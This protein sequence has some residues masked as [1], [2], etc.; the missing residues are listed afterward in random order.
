[1]IDKIITFDN[2]KSFKQKLDASVDGELAKKQDV[3]SDLE[4]IRTKAN[5]AASA[6]SL[7]AVATSGEYD[8]LVNKPEEASQSDIEDLFPTVVAALADIKNLNDDPNVD[9]VYVMLSGDIDSG[10]DDIVFRKDAEIDLNGHEL[11]FDDWGLEVRGGAS[12]TVENGEI[13]S[14]ESAFYVREQASLTINRGDYTSTNNF[15]IGTNGTAGK[16]DNTITING[17]TFNAEMSAAGKAEGYI[18]C[19]I[20]VANS[21]TL[22]VKSGTVLNVADGVGILCRSGHTVIEDGVIIN[23]TGTGTGYVGDSK[24][25][26]PAGKA[27]V[28][29]LKAGYPGGTPTIE[30]HSAYEVYILE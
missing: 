25:D 23:V 30:N 22:V 9:H 24:I 21:D 6:D 7:S 3:I 27:I 11:S 1:M 5:D 18:A 2:L 29:D 12:L 15:V 16:G 14:S 13:S 20:Y 17:G 4:E 26:V 8:D 19:G 10:S 28:L